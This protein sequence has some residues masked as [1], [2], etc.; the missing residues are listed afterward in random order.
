MPVRPASWQ[1]SSATGDLLLS[2]TALQDL[3]YLL[4]PLSYLPELK[5]CHAALRGMTHLFDITVPPSYAEMSVAFPCR[6]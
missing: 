3:A 6:T 5:A 2:C 1:Y 4:L